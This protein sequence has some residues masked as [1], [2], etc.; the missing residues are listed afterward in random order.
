MSP[1]EI[2]HARLSLGLSCVRLGA[3]AGVSEATIRKLERGQDISAPARARI[4]AALRG[5][6]DAA[7]DGPVVWHPGDADAAKELLGALALRLDAGRGAAP[8]PTDALAAMQ[9]RILELRCGCGHVARQPLT[10]LLARHGP[11]AR[12]PAVVARMRCQDCG[13]LPAEA[14]LLPQVPPGP[15]PG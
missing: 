10:H 11:H 7:P 12:L 5:R 3:L 1:E 14:A 9:D 6:P 13:R 15:I 8:A 2:K 4:L